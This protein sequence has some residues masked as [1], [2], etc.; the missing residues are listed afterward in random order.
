MQKKVTDIHE[1]AEE[2]SS[3]NSDMRLITDVWEQ[4]H[5]IN[6]CINFR[7]TRYGDPAAF[8]KKVCQMVEFN[9]FWIV[10]YNRGYIPS[11]YKDFYL[12]SHGK[13][14]HS[15]GYT[16]EHNDLGMRW[17]GWMERDIAAKITL[18]DSPDIS[19]VYHDGA[20]IVGDVGQCT[21]LAFLLG[22]TRP[23]LK[24][25]DAWISVKEYKDYIWQVG[26]A[27]D[28]S[29]KDLFFPGTKQSIGFSNP[30]EQPCKTYNVNP[31]F[32]G[33]QQ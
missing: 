10:E 16:D 33:H 8:L 32:Q 17:A 31:K 5:V 7:S 21:S 23:I 6:D 14:M 2:I 1:Y 26:T 19:G 15:G 27:P 3:I 13:W 18:S 20:K 30:A 4:R 12:Q 22:V 25:G 9:A 29:I 24:L 28:T 11:N